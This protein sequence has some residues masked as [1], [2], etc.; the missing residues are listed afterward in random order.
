MDQV[1]YYTR[2]PRFHCV[3]HTTT[4]NSIDS[5]LRYLLLR[6]PYSVSAHA[7]Y[8]IPTYQ[9]LV[10]LFDVR[11]SVLIVERLRVVCCLAQA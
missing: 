1:H 5:T 6:V 2:P 11:R 8:V 7:R 4:V 3:N 10:R 9:Q